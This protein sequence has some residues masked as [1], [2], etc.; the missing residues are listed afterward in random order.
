[1]RQALALALAGLLLPVGVR[2]QPT[3]YRPVTIATVHADPAGFHGQ[4]VM[5]TGRVEQ[6]GNRLVVSDGT[7]SIRVL[8]QLPVDD[9]SYDLRGVVL[10]VGR[11]RKG[12]PILNRLSF[13]IHFDEIYRE[14]WPKPGE[15]LVMAAASVTRA[16]GAIVEIAGPRPLP[17]EVNFSVPVEGE[18][19]VRQDTRIR[20][21]FSRELDAASLKNRIRLSYS[22]SDSVERGEAQPPGLAFTITYD[23]GTRVL[24]IRPTQP[25][26]RF[27]PVKLDLLE[28][29]AGSDGSALHSWSLRFRTGGS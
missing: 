24:E 14:G 28:G 8:S 6:R 13:K 12:D 4:S 25:L 22:A 7:V 1:V 26:E 11:L 20:L 15:E 3:P 21:Q 16:S 18:A 29:I 5:V 23:A 9:G 10:D 17:L 19:D 2:A 27:R